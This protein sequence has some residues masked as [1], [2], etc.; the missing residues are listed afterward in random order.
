MNNALCRIVFGLVIPLLFMGGM[1]AGRTGTFDFALIGDVPYTQEEATT[2]FPK[3][4]RELNS[5]DLQF[6]VHD[7]D[8]KSNAIPCTDEIFAE[9]FKQFEMF[10]H[11]LIY[12]F[13]D[14]EWTDCGQ[15]GA[16][17]DPVERLQ[18]LRAI[19]TRGEHSLGRRKLF[20]ERQSNDP[21]YRKFRENVRWEMGSVMF[22][23]LDIPGGGNNYGTREFAERNAANM[24]WLKKTFE[25]ARAE[26]R[27][28]VMIVIQANPF[29]D[30][31][32]PVREGY[33]DLVHSLEIETLSFGKPVVLVHGDSHRFR[34]DAPLV[35]STSK[36]RI[37]NFLRVETFGHPDVHWVRATVDPQDP[38]VFTF[39]PQR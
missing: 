10:E 9:R 27:S 26:N 7:G 14:N 28:A 30:D 4:I 38:N 3:M 19:F 35:N 18:K 29:P 34:I 12:V 2:L 20:L 33:R 6:I 24:E 13:G 25:V 1:S 5:A 36:R 17:F 11:P 39:R 31:S 37:D 16:G 32:T 21:R 22:V 8:I 23:A 15:A